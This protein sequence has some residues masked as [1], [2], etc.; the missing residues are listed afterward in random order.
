MGLPVNLEVLLSARLAPA[1]A[2][3][4]QATVDPAVRRSR[5]ADFQSG[6][7]L[8][9]AGPLGRSPRDI[10][11]GVLA[12]ADLAGVATA[13][14]SGPGFLN[15]RL[16]DEVLAA[17]VNGLAGDPRLGVPRTPHPERV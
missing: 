9:L 14:I 15:L 10:A 8:P 2:E 5:H 16:T 3:V 6:A 12:A 11:A 17:G 13:E 4:A 7:A 1:F